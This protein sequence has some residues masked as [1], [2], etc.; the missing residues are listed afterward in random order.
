MLKIKILEKLPK[1]LPKLNAA[2]RWSL[3]VAFL[4]LGMVGVWMYVSRQ[5]AAKEAVAKQQLVAAI[6]IKTVTALGKLAPQGEIIKLSA[7]TSV[8][9]VKIERLLVKEGETV[10]ARQVIAILDSR[11]R[12][13]AAV[14][15]AKARVSVAQAS[16]VTTK[17]GAKQ[18]EINAQRATIT[19]LQAERVTEIQLLKATLARVIAET[20]TQSE[21]LTATLARVIAE[22]QTQ[23]E[24]QKGAIAEAQAGLVN[25]QA[26]YKRYAALTQQGAVSRST[27]DSRLLTLQTSQQRVNQAQANLTRIESS[28]KQQ[29]NEARANLRRI[30]ESGKQQI[31]EARANLR[32]S[33][34]SRYQQVRE[35]QFTLNR[36][37]EVR[38]VD[39]MSAETNIKSALATQKVAEQS[40]AKAYIRSPIDG[41][42][43]EIFARPG[44]VVGTTD[45]IADLGKTS[46]MYGVVEVYN[47]D[48]SKIRAGQQ[49]KITS[50]SLSGELRGKV[51]R[52][53]IHVKRQDVI[54]ADPTSNIDDRVIEVHVILD[55]ASSLK[56]AKFTN[57]QIQAVIELNS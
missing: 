46:Q 39:V 17:A 22:T 21:S 57:L 31:N 12:L 53:G 27:G 15:E 8:D 14:N 55:P 34:T 20:Q 26:E 5:Q 29:I 48:V 51:E 37:V 3:T 56:A 11:G 1:K 25:A 52:V 45:G 13:E 33:E 23:S 32:R 18:G 44:E 47:S 6:K 19:R 4:A 50:N 38:P 2:W 28:G 24:S 41:Q 49:V 30:Q 36:I 40:L 43:F 54:N 35:S 16:L 42:I 10:T 7:P 9:G